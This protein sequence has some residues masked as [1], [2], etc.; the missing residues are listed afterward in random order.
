MKNRLNLF[1]Q[2]YPTAT[3]NC[4]GCLI[5]FCSVCCHELSSKEKLMGPPFFDPF[6]LYKFICFISPAAL[7][8]YSFP[9][10][11]RETKGVTINGSSDC[12]G[13]LGFIIRNGNTGAYFKMKPPGPL[14]LLSLNEILKS[15]GNSLL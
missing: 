9:V 7:A 1:E 4:S 12:F 2:N 6:H 8:N 14:E 13:F 3:W 10:Y 11:F 15:F 5:K